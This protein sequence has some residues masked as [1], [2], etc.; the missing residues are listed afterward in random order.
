MSTSHCSYCG[1]MGRYNF[2]VYEKATTARFV[3]VWNLQ[4]HVIECQRLEPAA[5]LSS[6]MA[7]TIERLE[8][9]GWRAEGTAEYS[10]VFISREAD[11]RLLMLTPRDPHCIEGQSFS[12]FR[13]EVRL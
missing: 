4:W 6:A 3:V 2:P 12:P 7:A 10:F 8:G 9:E 1:S 5:D 11:R 13:S